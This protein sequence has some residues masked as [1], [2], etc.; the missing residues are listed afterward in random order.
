MNPSAP[1]PL[2]D[3]QERKKFTLWFVLIFYALAVYKLLNGL[4]LFQNTPFVFRATFDG[5]A[6]VFMLSGLHLFLL[7]QPLACL[8]LDV[9]FYS[10]P[11]LYW[12]AATTARGKLM[13]GTWMLMINWI[14]VLSYSLFPIN[15]IEGHIAWLLMPLV[16]MTPSIGTF[17][18]MMHGLRYFFFFFSPRRDVGKFTRVAYLKANK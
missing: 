12:F 13:A 2:F 4:W 18:H 15:S 5:A 1:I 8:V 6:W 10:A 16:L 7:Q 14:Y 9:L 17:Y 3:E 11:L